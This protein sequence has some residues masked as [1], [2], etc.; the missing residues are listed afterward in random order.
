MIVDYTSC[1]SINSLCVHNINIENDF[2]VYYF[3]IFI[4]FI[5]FIISSLLS[6]TR[7]IFFLILSLLV[8]PSELE[9][10]KELPGDRKLIDLLVKGEFN[11]I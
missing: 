7:F 4:F 8:M 6:T 2:K 11:L 1:A 10:A 5:F 9:F 3:I